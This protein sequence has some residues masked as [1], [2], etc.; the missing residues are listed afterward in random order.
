[1]TL[2]QLEY[3]VALATH[4]HFGRAAESCGVSQPTL[5][6]QIQKLEEALGT[7][8]FDRSKQPVRPTEAGER[9]AAQ[10]RLVL[11]ESNQIHDL[12]NDL[13]SGLSGTFRIGVIHT[14]AP[15]LMPPFLPRFADA[16]PQA[17]LII[18]ERKTSRILKGLR[19]GDIDLGILVTPVDDPAI[20]ELPLFQ[21]PFLAYLPAG[22][23]LRRKQRVHRDDLKGQ[24][25]WV[26]GEGHCFREQALSLCDRPS[27]GAHPNVLYE[28]GSIETLKNLVRN[29]DAMTIVPELSVTADDPF[30]RRFTAPEPV[31]QVSLVVR[32]PFVRQRLLQSMA[33]ALR[34][35]VQ[36]KLVRSK[37]AAV[38]PR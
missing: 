31:R 36:D 17:R 6:V 35:C 13:D 33:D 20:E 19:H 10:A 37:Q 32:K 9:V 18:D 38:V 23:P 3:L 5:T 28:S 29:G 12:V 16:H 30:V 14:L 21:E 26:L 4:R 27:S 15:Y 7:Q 25:L 1:M 8:L 11:R 22:H 24:S 34:A 2:Q